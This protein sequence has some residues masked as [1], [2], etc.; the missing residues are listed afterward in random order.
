MLRLQRGKK[1]RTRE[2]KP[3]KSG[4]ARQRGKKR[5]DEREEAEQKRRSEAEAKRRAEA[6]AEERHKQELAEQ[7]D[8]QRLRQLKAD[9]EQRRREAEEHHR[10]AEE[11]EERHAKEASDERN[12]QELAGQEDAQRLQQLKA[13]GEQRRREAGENL[14]RAEEAEERRAKEASDERN[15]QEL[16]EQEEAERLRQ[17]KADEAAQAAQMQQRQ[18]AE[19]QRRRAH[20]D[21]KRRVRDDAE[22]AELRIRRDEELREARVREEAFWAAMSPEEAERMRGMLKA[23]GLYQL[24][25]RQNERVISDI[26][27]QIGLREKQFKS[28]RR[29]AQQADQDKKDARAEQ[30]RARDDTEKLHKK[31][32]SYKESGVNLNLLRTKHE[33]LNAEIARLQEEV[34]PVRTELQGL[35]KRFGASEESSR[36]QTIRLAEIKAQCQQANAALKAEQQEELTTLSVAQTEEVAA[37]EVSWQT[38]VTDL[39]SWQH[40]EAA[41]LRCNLEEANQRKEGLRMD[42][43]DSCDQLLARQREGTHLQQQ[44][45]DSRQE[46]VDLRMQL[47]TFHNTSGIMHQSGMSLDNSMAS[48]SYF[49]AGPGEDPRLD[50]E[51]QMMRR[52]CSQLQRDCMKWHDALEQKQAECER[53][54][55]RSFDAP[56]HALAGHVTSGPFTLG[57]EDGG[58]LEGSS[59]STSTFQLFNSP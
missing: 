18:E 49:Q 36:M 23:V 26:Q 41:R 17:I 4:E 2:K 13:D 57:P 58:G 10:R 37:L 16:K 38:Q 22:E 11:A 5:E 34:A 28:V 19:E 9:G 6:E 30:Q 44:L 21:E 3:I 15:K 56:N 48:Q 31:I 1:E 59:I 52:S 14:S 42:R 12:K 20:E 29:R 50:A 51:L 39:R 7:E 55:K 32:E 27:G 43:D 54:R 40:G 45:A 35:R 8:T 25:L 53:W 47:K 33:A 24:Q 46:V